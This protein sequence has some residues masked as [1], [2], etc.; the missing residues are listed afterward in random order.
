MENSRIRAFVEI[1]LRLPSS[2]QVTEDICK[3]QQEIHTQLSKRPNKRYGPIHLLFA[4]QKE[5]KKELAT[6]ERNQTKLGN[7][8]TLIHNMI[9]QSLVTI[10]QEDTQSFMDL[11]KV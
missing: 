3:T 4:R 8:A 2:S 9:E 5:L 11:L 6:A 1:V 7:F 10:V